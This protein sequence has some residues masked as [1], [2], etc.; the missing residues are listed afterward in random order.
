MDVGNN[1]YI[2]TAKTSILCHVII[3]K[4]HGA[5]TGELSSATSS[6]LFTHVFTH[7]LGS[8]RC[9]KT[10]DARA[11]RIH[12]RVVHEQTEWMAATKL[13]WAEVITMAARLVD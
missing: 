9:R 1:D 13:V 2:N 8:S 6:D 11:F 10:A 4:P 3:R 7:V 12:P 5:G